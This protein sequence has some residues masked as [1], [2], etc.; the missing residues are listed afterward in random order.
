VGSLPRYVKTLMPK[1]KT[2]PL[3]RARACLL[4][5]A[6]DFCKSDAEVQLARQQWREI[7][8]WHSD[9][10]I[11][12]LPQE[13]SEDRPAREALPRSQWC[14][15]CIRIK[16]NAVDYNYAL[17]KRRSSKVRMKRAYKF[18]SQFSGLKDDDR[19]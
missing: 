6:I 11:C 17:F 16:A 12:C 10:G 2:P 8:N 3:L 13:K 9:E 15:V 1:T 5:A 14:E 18:I 19:I 7:R 4:Q